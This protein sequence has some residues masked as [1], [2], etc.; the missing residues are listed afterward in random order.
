MAERVLDNTAKCTLVVLCS[1]RSGRLGLNHTGL[2][3]EIY[4]VCRIW[5]L[6]R[7]F[8]ALSIRLEING[9][10]A[11]QSLD[12]SRPIE[13]VIIQPDLEGLF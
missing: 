1:T 3:N 13:A 12:A 6:A 11:I 5:W 9:K 4:D 2:P 8:T 7:A 10:P